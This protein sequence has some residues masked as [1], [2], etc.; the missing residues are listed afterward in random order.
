MGILTDKE[1][2]NLRQYKY[3]GGDLSL[4]YKHVLSPL[5][6]FCVDN[7]IPTSMA[8]NLI[9]FVGLMV[10]F[11]ATVLTLVFNP[12]LSADCPR[13][14]SAYSGISI[15]IYQTL[16]NMDGKQARRT[17]SSS[18]LGMLFDHGCDAINAAISTISYASVLGAGW[19]PTVFLFLYCAFTSFY[20]QT[21]EEY[22]VGSMILPI[23]NGPSEG[24]LITAS[25]GVVG[26]IVGPRFF[27]TVSCFS[28]WLETRS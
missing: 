11:S 16:D 12:T 9:T 26:G 24:L 14:L 17:G 23:F 3:S 10:A 15:F 7:F 21:W 8:P 27:S 5:A 18:P 4:T 1:K 6:Q 19:T 22:Y 2:V 25:I 28:F 20:I 13:W